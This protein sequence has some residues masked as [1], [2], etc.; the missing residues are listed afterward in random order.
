MPQVYISTVADYADKLSK[1]NVH[2]I[3][4]GDIKLVHKFDSGINKSVNS[5]DCKMPKFNIQF[6]IIYPSFARKISTSRFKGL[7]NVVIKKL[8]D[9]G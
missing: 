9:I 4:S 2:L 3:G 1:I 7:Q 6:G 5:N 8:K